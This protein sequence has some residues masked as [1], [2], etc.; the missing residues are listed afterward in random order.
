[1]NKKDLVYCDL[2]CENLFMSFNTVVER[3]FKRANIFLKFL[4]NCFPHFCKNIHLIVTTQQVSGKR[5]EGKEADSLEG[6]EYEAAVNQEK[7]D[8]RKSHRELVG[9]TLPQQ[10]GGDQEEVSVAALN[11]SKSQTSL[12]FNRLS[13]KMQTPPQYP[14]YS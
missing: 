10:M 7:E 6:G 13:L 4:V 3:G 8:D 2:V 14:K 11:V 9:G 5:Y 12:H 1:M